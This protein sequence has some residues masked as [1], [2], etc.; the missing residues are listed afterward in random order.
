MPN[1]PIGRMEAAEFGVTKPVGHGV[2]QDSASW[3]PSAGRGHRRGD[4]RDTV[5]LA[6]DQFIAVCDLPST[7][8]D[9]ARVTANFSNGATVEPLTSTHAFSK[10]RCS[11]GWLRIDSD[12]GSDSVSLVPNS[13]W[14]AA[15]AGS[16]SIHP[17]IEW[18]QVKIGS[19]PST[20]DSNSALFGLGGTA[21]QGFPPLIVNQSDSDVEQ[22]SC[23]QDP[24]IGPESSDQR[25][26]F[27]DDVKSA[28]VWLSEDLSS[29][30]TIENA[31][32][33]SDA[34]G[35]AVLL[36]SPVD[37]Q[38]AQNIAEHGGYWKGASHWLETA[39][40]PIVHI[41]LLAGA[42]YLQPVFSRR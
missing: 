31:V 24:C 11:L 34:A 19:S 25:L 32:F 17:V 13:S 4:G 6:A 37:E 39:G 12:S 41:P 40:E 15:P 28:P 9:V 23:E 10:R 33:L 35:G 5:S 7:Q 38:V 16:G 42:L 2:R 14:F 3:P 21:P 26:C 20:T 8:T 18:Q 22:T 27:R 1:E 30:P 36:R 29:L